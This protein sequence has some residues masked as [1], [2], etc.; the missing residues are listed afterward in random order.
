MQ[1]QE[2]RSVSCLEN[3]KSVLV[4]GASGF[5]GQ[6]LCRK[7]LASGIRVKG[8]VRSSEKLSSLPEG[9]IAVQ[10]GEISGDTSWD[11]ALEGIGAVV[12]LAGIAH[13]TDKRAQDLCEYRRVNVL[14]TE[15][16]ARACARA[17]VRRVVFLSSIGVN[18]DS[19]GK[20]PFSENDIPSPVGAYALSKWEAEQALRR[21]ARD[22]GLEVVILRPPLVYG[23]KAPGNFARLM[24]LIK[25]G[26][27]LPLG[28]V[29]NTRSFIYIENLMDAVLSCLEHPQ[30]SGQTFLLSDGEDLSTPDLIRK[31]AAA[32]N[33]KAILF[34]LPLGILKALGILA[35][36][37]EAMEKLTGSLRVDSRKIRHL[38]GWSPPF[39][40]KEGIAEAVRGSL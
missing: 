40:L 21:V 13:R 3:N 34:S 7:L 32:M 19:T 6:A 16:L 18:G 12:H 37:R 29:S 25:R 2:W 33:K 1:K 30:A 39:T 28:R 11:A 23:P 35:G 9:A 8:A 27:P 15:C 24:S 22:T 4:T 31:I 17:G 20:G 5:L 26:M 38:L 10:V 36:Q 14:G